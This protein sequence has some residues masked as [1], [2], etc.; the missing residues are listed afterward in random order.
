MADE[1]AR[2]VVLVT[3]VGGSGAVDV[4]RSLH[5]SGR[6][7]V[8]AA[9]VSEYAAGFAFAD[10]TY[11]VPMGEDPAFE[12]AAR[13]I[14]RRERPDFVV[15]SVDEEIPVFHRLVAEEGGHTRVL[16]P[17]PEFCRLAHDKWECTRALAGAGV[18]V[19]RTYLA[20]DV[21]DDVY[22]AVVKPRTG[23]GSRGVAY[24]ASAAELAEYLETAPGSPSDFIVQERIFGTEFTVSAVVGLGGPLLA[25][26]PKEVLVKKG[27]TH[28]AVTRAVP[29]IDDVCRAIQE[30]L[31]ADGPFNVQLML[32]PDGVPYV[33]EVNPRFST[34]VSLT[35]GAGVDE[36]DAIMR[37]AQGRD[38]GNLVFQPDLIM[39]RH[40]AQQF[41]PESRWRART[42]G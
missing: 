28:S 38:P 26:V 14:L 10:A 32:S 30:Q 21:A 18:P 1:E 9:D 39:L 36:V 31:R 23:R 15:T 20:G 5:E 42:D 41:V 35:M 4:A 16:T 27:I 34:T 8:V 17:T 37:H 19:P 25:V 13:E 24:P 11:V 3:A 6:Y 7:R 33:F 29:A 2:T 40:Y 12:G 22:P